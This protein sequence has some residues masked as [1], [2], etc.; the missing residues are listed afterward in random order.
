M[1]RSKSRP[2]VMFGTGLLR[3]LHHAF[4]PSEKHLAKQ[5]VH[6]TTAAMATRPDFP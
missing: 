6:T 2:P 5:K 1:N 3:F 4:P